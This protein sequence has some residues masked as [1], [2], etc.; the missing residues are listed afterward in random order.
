LK[1][2][3]KNA[4]KGSV[5]Q[6]ISFFV[7]D[8]FQSIHDPTIAKPSASVEKNIRTWMIQMANPDQG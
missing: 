3:N 5:Q 4:Q 1:N 8:W 6:K 2:E 7:K